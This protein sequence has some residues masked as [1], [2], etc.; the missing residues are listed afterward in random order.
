MG[1]IADPTRHIRTDIYFNN[2]RK[3]P[4]ESPSDR[5]AWAR[6]A[7]IAANGSVETSLALIG[8]LARPPRQTA[9]RDNQKC[10]CRQEH[11]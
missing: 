9:K 1:A 8:P 11:R 10:N 3:F 7:D 4:D 6:M 5:L 2:A